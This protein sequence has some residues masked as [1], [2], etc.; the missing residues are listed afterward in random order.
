M[1]AV[2]TFLV[3]AA[4]A[5]FAVDAKLRQ[6]RYNQ[7][8]NEYANML[9]AMLKAYRIEVKPSDH[10]LKEALDK[11]G[12]LSRDQ[13]EE[14]GSKFAKYRH[15]VIKAKQAQLDLHASISEVALKAVALGGLTAGATVAGSVVFTVLGTVAL[16]CV[17]RAVYHKITAGG[18]PELRTLI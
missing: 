3:G 4:Y 17:G 15:N 8:T 13:R 7:K 18:K 11:A 2:A 9:N 6:N 5:Y 16:F 14:I 1:M 12:I 10:C